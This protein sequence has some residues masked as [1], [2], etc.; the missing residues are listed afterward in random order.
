MINGLWYHGNYFPS[1]PTQSPPLHPT[2]HARVHKLTHK[3]LYELYHQWLGH[4]G[5]KIL[6]KIHKHI[7]GIPQ[8][9]GNCFYLCASCALSKITR[10]KQSP[11]ASI[12]TYTL[13]PQPDFLDLVTQL[14]SADLHC[15]ACFHMD[16]GFLHG[17]YIEKDEFG[18]QITSIDK[19][20]SYLLIINCKSRYKGSYSATPNNPHYNSWS[21]SSRLLKLSTAT[22]S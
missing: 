20:N 17:K 5:K 13:L 22:I 19:Y 10:R 9:K 3:A 8:L 6:S 1:K 2:T 4:C 16:F 18:K 7:K 14:P 15:G 11:S 12:D 21:N